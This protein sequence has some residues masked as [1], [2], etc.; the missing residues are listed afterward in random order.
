MLFMGFAVCWSDSNTQT[1]S[2]SVGTSLYLP[3]QFI[4]TFLVKYSKTDQT[5]KGT[6]LL[7]K[8]GVI[9]HALMHSQQ[10]SWYYILA[11]QDQDTHFRQ[12]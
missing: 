12:F 6:K 3:R 10:T 1:E 11:V 2:D 5:V 4:F 8:S 7:Y 9:F